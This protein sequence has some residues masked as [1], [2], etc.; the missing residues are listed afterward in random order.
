MIADDRIPTAV[1]LQRAEVPDIPGSIDGSQGVPAGAS[2]IP[3]HRHFQ[4]TVGEVIVAD[5]R[6]PAAV[7]A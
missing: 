7:Q 6:I 5:N 1:Q 3:A 2:G 4:V